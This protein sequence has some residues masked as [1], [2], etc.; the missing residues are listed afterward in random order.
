MKFSSEWFNKKLFFGF[1]ILVALLA[2]IDWFLF[3]RT[4]M[5]EIKTVTEAAKVVGAKITG[6]PGGFA[7]AAHAHAASATAALQTAPV[8]DASKATPEQFKVWFDSEINLMNQYNVNEDQMQQRYLELTAKM[9]PAQFKQLSVVARTK[10]PNV[11]ER[12]LAAYLL[13]YSGY[14][15]I[16]D[17]SALVTA[18]IQL[19][20]KPEPHSVAETQQVQ[21]RA[22]RV[23]AINR[24]ANLAQG[25]DPAQAKKAV[26]E[27]KRLAATLKDASLKNYAQNKLK[28]IS[29]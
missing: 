15:N 3:G 18:P 27:L 11:N 24:L 7:G 21:E 13:G 2:L 28:E 9:T 1:I 12:I 22:L 5:H 25:N 10:S 8:I 16:N 29:K 26:A 6:K 14:A 19:D 23:L 20:G 17:L 4:P